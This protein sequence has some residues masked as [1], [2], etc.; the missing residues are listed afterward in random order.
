M[1]ALPQM[2]LETSVK[3][4][5]CVSLS[6]FSDTPQKKMSKEGGRYILPI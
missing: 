3:Q 2:Q 6:R 1:D 5:R 4:F